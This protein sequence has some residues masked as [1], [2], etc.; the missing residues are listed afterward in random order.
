MAHSIAIVGLGG[1]FPGCPDLERFWE[2]I[3]SGTDVARE[4]PPGRWLLGSGDALRPGEPSP[5]RVISTR[6]GV[7]GLRD[8]S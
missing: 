4:V 5:D 8:L 1:I 6:G 2:T 7:S 3:R